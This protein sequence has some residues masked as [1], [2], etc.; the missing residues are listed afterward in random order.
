MTQTWN[1]PVTGTTT[2]PNTMAL[3]DRGGATLLRDLL[4]DALGE[5]DFISAEPAPHEDLAELAQMYRRVAER[6]AK[7]IRQQLRETT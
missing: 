5:L 2:A 3:L 6:V 4:K 7:R 1:P